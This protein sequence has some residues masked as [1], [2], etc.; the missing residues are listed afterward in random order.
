MSLRQGSRSGGSWRRRLLFV[1]AAAVV[2]PGAVIS[3]DA[4]PLPES[5]KATLPEKQVMIEATI[6]KAPKG[7]FTAVFPEARDWNK[8]PVQWEGAESAESP[9][10]FGFRIEP[11]KG[12]FESRYESPSSLGVLL[13]MPPDILANQKQSETTELLKTAKWQAV[14]D[15]L[16]EREDVDVLCTPRLMC[17]NA[18]QA[19][20]ETAGTDRI[21]L[22]VT[23]MVMTDG[24]ALTCNFEYELDD[25]RGNRMIKKSSPL[26][27]T[28]VV[29]AGSVYVHRLIES[30]GQELVLVLKANEIK[31]APVASISNRSVTETLDSQLLTA[32]DNVPQHEPT[33]FVLKAM[34]AEVDPEA[35]LTFATPVPTQTIKMTRSDGGK[36]P[37]Q[38]GSTAFSVPFESVTELYR[39][40]QKSHKLQILSRPQIVTL[41]GKPSRIEVGQQVTPQNEDDDGFRGIRLALTPTRVD[42]KT[43]LSGNL[44]HRVQTDQVK[45]TEYDFQSVEISDDEASLIRLKLG[46]SKPDLLLSLEAAVVKPEPQPQKTVRVRVSGAVEAPGL[47]EVPGGENNLI[48]AIAMAGGLTKKASDVVVIHRTARPVETVNGAAQV[49]EDTHNGF[50]RYNFRDMAKARLPRLKSNDR[51][52]VESA[53]SASELPPTFPRPYDFT[54]LLGYGEPDPPLPEEILDIIRK[55]VDANSWDRGKITPTDLSPILVV[56]QTLKNHAIIGQ[57]VEQLRHDYLADV[58]LRTRT[59]RAY[60]VSSLVTGSG[61]SAAI[62]L[63]N[64]QRRIVRI[65]NPEMFRSGRNVIRTHANT[66]SLVVRADKETHEQI[67]EL[68]AMHAEGRATDSSAHTRSIRDTYRQPLLAG[69]GPGFSQESTSPATTPVDTTVRVIVHG[70]VSKSGVYEVPAGPNNLMAAIALAGGLR[71]D[72]GDVINIRRTAKGARQ[73][74]KGGIETASYSQAYTYKQT[75][76][77]KIT[78]VKAGTQL[79][80]LQDRDEVHVLVAE[81]S[82]LSTKQAP[83]QSG[84]DDWNLDVPLAFQSAMTQVKNY[85]LR[86]KR[87][88]VALKEAREKGQSTAPLERN[89]KSLRLQLKAAR[90]L[91]RPRL[92]SSAQQMLAGFGTQRIGQPAPTPQHIASEL[93]A[94]QAGFKKTTPDKST[95]SVKEQYTVVTYSVP[96]LLVPFGTESYEVKLAELQARIRSIDPQSWRTAGGERTMQLNK[97]TLALVIRCPESAHD[98]IV[99][100]LGDL[101]NRQP[102]QVQLDVS[103]IETS[104]EALAQEP[105]TVIA[106]KLSLVGDD[107]DID[108][109]AL[110][111]PRLT[112]FS[113]VTAEVLTERIHMQFRA[114]IEGKTVVVTAIVGDKA[115]SW[116]IPDGKTGLASLASGVGGKAEDADGKRYFLKVKASIIDA[117]EEEELILQPATSPAKMLMQTPKGVFGEEEEEELILGGQ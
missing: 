22:Q 39:R 36:E 20:C 89:L 71:A 96:D 58:D 72:C 116:V 70:A 11:K 61:T 13:P 92:D 41:E 86:I 56:E 67:A 102:G 7:V 51:I 111:A 26:H 69:T 104:A 79:V 78:N 82:Q 73:V 17:R 1:V 91:R 28:P 18:Q 60:D 12:G 50:V 47:F 23:P 27:F 35:E 42:G 77:A 53:D 90:N 108:G 62:M 19:S 94:S 103:V 3:Q 98:K 2:L 68:L 37:M 80:S 48:N 16:K 105:K 34:I 33:A 97:S 110:A 55:S 114:K 74:R 65:V 10:G 64:L 84:T 49:S 30:F 109:N 75:I 99:A 38:V 8:A 29:P 76:A 93:Y 117:V 66:K 45:T 4:K 6:I 46:D 54:D 43:V 100:L 31:R 14:L 15:V 106:S 87:A 5:K 9:V 63:K 24:V 44:L 101:R 85:E 113:G 21:R 95:S 25:G 107:F 59:P 81:P 52:V 112:L 40:I 115:T 88:E 57:R 32:A 83:T